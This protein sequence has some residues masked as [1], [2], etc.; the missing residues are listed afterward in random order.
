MGRS[1]IL[2]GLTSLFLVVI[3]A[4]GVCCTGFASRNESGAWFGN[5]KNL[6]SWHWKDD[7]GKQ[8]DETGEPRA[9]AVSSNGETLY[10]GGTYA[11]S[12][13][14]TFFAS[15]E[16]AQSKKASRASVAGIETDVLVETSGSDAAI[17]VTAGLSSDLMQG[18]FDWSISYPDS[19]E[20]AADADTS[21]AV[22]EAIGLRNADKATVEF[23][24]KRNFNAPIIL[25]VTLRGTDKTATCVLR[26]FKEVSVRRIDA[27]VESAEGTPMAFN[28]YWSRG[29][30]FVYGNKMAIASYDYC[31]AEDVQP[32]VQ[33]YVK[34][35]LTFCRGGDGPAGISVPIADVKGMG[36][37]MPLWNEYRPFA[38]DQVI[39][40]YNSFDAAHKTAIKYA[41]YMAYKETGGKNF[42]EVDVRFDYQYTLS[43]RDPDFYIFRLRSEETTA[44]Y[45]ASD[46]ASVVPNVTLNKN[47]IL[48]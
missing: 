42:F 39:S 23:W 22:D 41:L 7:G 12:D 35:P 11:I 10:A 1:K 6:S 18:E 34:F 16:R 26:C 20:L 38:L 9:V 3:L 32:R 43:M 45:N 33:K 13:S 19:N 17:S 27:G 31:V 48:K 24:K 29:D 36:N 30:G 14:I 8:S 25:T 44:D 5:F 28:V 47:Y 40:D 37:N 21:I 4:A 2:T 15:D 46:F